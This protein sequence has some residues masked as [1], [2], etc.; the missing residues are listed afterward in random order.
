MVL[1]KEEQPGIKQLTLLENDTK[2]LTVSKP[3]VQNGA[4][5][6]KT[7]ALGVLR[8]IPGLVFLYS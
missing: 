6:T 3:P 2:F 5:T 8:S 7:N 4:E 1:Q